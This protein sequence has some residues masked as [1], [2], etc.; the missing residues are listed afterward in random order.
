MRRLALAVAAAA[1]ALS[2]AA[3]QP[4]LAQ[5]GEPAYRPPQPPGGSGV[6]VY[7]GGEA[8]PRSAVPVYRGSAAPPARPDRRGGAP[9]A[10]VTTVGGDR[11]WL[12]DPDADRL[13]ACR[14]AR[15]LQVGRSRIRC[16][17]GRLAVD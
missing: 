10:G 6:A 3:P 9:L 14:L 4:A 16:T 5:G 7:R 13:I 2:L 17:E 1:A 12:V 8:A 11:L 15:T